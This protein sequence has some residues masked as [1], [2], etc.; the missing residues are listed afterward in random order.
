M[1][2]CTTSHV[3]QSGNKKNSGVIPRTPAS[4]EGRG[5]RLNHPHFF[6]LIRDLVAGPPKCESVGVTVEIPLPGQL[7]SSIRA[8]GV[9]DITSAI[10]ISG[11]TRLNF[12]VVSHCQRKRWLTR[13]RKLA[14][15]R[16]I[17]FHRWNTLLDSRVTKYNTFRLKFILHPPPFPFSI[18]G[19]TI[20]RILTSFYSHWIALG[21]CQLSASKK[22][23]RAN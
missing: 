8:T 4:G 3:R 15:Q 14:K 6:F 1:L 18:T 19:W 20:S 22:F 2:K 11:W 23:G 10:L 21:M 17:R 9:S 7:R 16:C 13:Y 12:S 5:G